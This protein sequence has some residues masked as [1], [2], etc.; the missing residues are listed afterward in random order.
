[1]D[2]I[3]ARV[4]AGDNLTKGVSTFM[5]EMIET[6]FILRVCNLLLL[7][8]KNI[9]CRR[10]LNEAEMLWFIIIIHKDCNSKYF[11]IN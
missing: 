11:S 8:I 5:A 7:N 6:S 1:M 3:L 4:G 9:T 2:G 10:L